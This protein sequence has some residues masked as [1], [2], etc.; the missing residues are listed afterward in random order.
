MG[1]L[2]KGTEAMVLIAVVVNL[3]VF[4]AMMVDLASG[5]Y[6][7]WFRKE[8]WKSD[9]L[10]RTGF[11]F[12]LYEGAL[13]IA[14]CVDLLVH[15]SKLYQWWGWDLVFGLPLVTLGVGIFWCVVE[16][17]SVRE[18]ADEKMHAKIAKAENLAKH[19]LSRDELIDI[20]AEA[21]KKSVMSGKGAS[22]G[23]E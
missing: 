5:M 10:K 12:V 20:M 19:V 21:L 2:F 11:K 1:E 17:L 3:V 8:E 16:F 4:V 22:D 13:L 18:K 23:K 14:T 6:K 15:F 9:I 7:A